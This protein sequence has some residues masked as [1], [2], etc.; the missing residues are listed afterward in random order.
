MGPRR[1]PQRTCMGCRQVK[2]KRELL[3]IVR[4]PQ[5]QV[6]LDPTGKAGGRGAYLCPQRDCWELALDQKALGHALKTTLSPEVRQVLREQAQF[7]PPAPQALPLKA[8]T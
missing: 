3:R 1:I 4:T 6:A 7:Y 8:V 5:G 2:P